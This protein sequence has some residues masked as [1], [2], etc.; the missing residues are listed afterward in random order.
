MKTTATK[1]KAGAIGTIAGT[2][3]GYMILMAIPEVIP[4]APWQAKA[5]L[6]VLVSAVITF[7]SVWI[8][9]ANRPKQ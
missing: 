5:A 1:A 3:I 6:F 2:G 9:P 7:A 4:D 8:A